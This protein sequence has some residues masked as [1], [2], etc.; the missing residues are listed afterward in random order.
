MTAPATRMTGVRGV[1]AWA[2]L[3]LVQIS[4]RCQR[5]G[6]YC[7]YTASTD[8]PF[9][10]VFEETCVTMPRQRRTPDPCNWLHA[11]DRVSGHRW[12]DQR[13]ACSKT[14]FGRN[15]PDWGRGHIAGQLSALVTWSWSCAS[16][17]DTYPSWSG[18]AHR[19]VGSGL[20]SWL[21]TGSQRVDQ[22]VLPANC[23]LTPG[24]ASYIV[25]SGGCAIMMRL[26]FPR[27]PVT[28][29]QRI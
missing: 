29:L 10:A 19:C 23:S 22:R 24:Q 26:L 8:K 6:Q 11:W 25:V 18:A 28:Q 21:P 12:L 3:A 5:A 14:T 15:Q 16:P 4:C 7:L 17:P 20:I 27:L 2:N 1:S 13:A 9:R